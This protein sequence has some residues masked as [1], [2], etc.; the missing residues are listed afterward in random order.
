MARTPR[1]RPLSRPTPRATLVTLVM[2][3]QGRHRRVAVRSLRTGRTFFECAAADLRGAELA[4]VTAERY[5]AER[6]FVVVMPAAE[7]PRV[8]A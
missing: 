6:G 7:A 3:S 8:A 4:V 5:C 2:E 1:P